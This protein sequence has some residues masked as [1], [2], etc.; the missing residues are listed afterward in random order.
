MRDLTQ[1]AF[2]ALE[3]LV[4]PGWKP[5]ATWPKQPKPQALIVY[6]LSRCYRLLS[7]PLGAIA[8]VC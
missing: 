6:V 8:L 4:N 1:R 5:R 7:G 2:V 3:V